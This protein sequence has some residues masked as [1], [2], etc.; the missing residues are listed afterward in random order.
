MRRARLLETLLAVLTVAVALWP[1]ETL[2][3]GTAWIGPT[4]VALAVVAATGLALRALRASAWLVVPAQVL[5]LV[6]AVTLLHGLGSGPYGLP[7]PDLPARLVAGG[8]QAATTIRSYAAPAP[9][10]PG[11]VMAVG[12][13]A[14]LV[15]V[16]VDHLVVARRAAT[17]AGFPLLLV[18]LVSVVNTA[19]ALPFRYF[20]ALALTWLLLL[21]EQQRSRLE[22]WST[23][24]PSLLE[25]QAPRSVG[26]GRP[27]AGFARAGRVL[28]VLAVAAAVALQLA[29][30]PVPTRF[31]GQGLGRQARES[32]PTI[33]FA[34]D[35]DVARSLGSRD[36]RP[37]L[38]YRTTGAQDTPPLAVAVADEYTGGHWRTARVP[39]ASAEVPSPHGLLPLPTGVEPDLPHTVA[40]SELF[41][42]GSLH[43]PQLAVPSLPLRVDTDVPW[44]RDDATGLVA[45]VRRPERYVV[46]YA[47]PTL[48]PKQ[49][50]ERTR[51]VVASETQVTTIDPVDLT[52]DQASEEAVTDT[53]LR[54]L[55]SAP[56]AYGPPDSAYAKA[57]AIQQYLRSPAFTYT[58]TLPPVTPQERAQGIT[59]DAITH[60]LRTRRGYCVQYA[61]AMALMARTQ[62]IPSR[63]VLGFLPGS[64]LPDGTRLVR[65]SDAHAW[66]ELML[67]GVGWT[68]FEPTPGGRSGLPPAWA[69]PRQQDA[70]SAPATRPTTRP[71]RPDRRPTATP[72]VASRTEVGLAEQA[73]GWFSRDRLVALALLVLAAGALLTTPVRAAAS[74]RRRLRSAGPAPAEVEVRW[75]ILAEQ[76]ADLGMPPPPGTTPRTLDAHYASH[77]LLS[78]ETK[79]ALSRVLAAVE[80]ARYA[81]AGTGASPVQVDDDARTVL[82]GVRATRTLGER[83]RAV[84]LPRAGRLC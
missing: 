75:T 76:L 81:P 11:L 27:E 13:L 35:V 3:R 39:A 17:L 54:V 2:L 61:T 49:I 59:P 16:V 26:A 10:V 60:F 80:R 5:A 34:S 57:V 31:L 41:D 68:R 20:A 33:S 58:L 55:E 14:G 51:R 73:R 12:A 77:P 64:Q 84:L 4:L 29:L 43:P 65:A 15:A 6:V 28:A 69:N 79:G 24:T 36:P 72:T 50:E 52:V 22:R 74:R 23:V 18:S 32:G 21:V 78:P 45:V 71:A 56:A 30:P 42:N 62:G 37:I 25:G 83:I 53:T 47:V 70:P 82:R 7:G 46:S 38:R 19:G 48:T 40:R 9:A 1:V 67:P 63:L 44:R 8:T 66:P